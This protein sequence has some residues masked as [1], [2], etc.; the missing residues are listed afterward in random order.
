[1]VLVVCLYCGRARP[2]V[3][4]P[5][6]NVGRDERGAERGSSLSAEI[7]VPFCPISALALRVSQNVQKYSATCAEMQNVDVDVAEGKEGMSMGCCRVEPATMF[8]QSQGRSLLGLL[9]AG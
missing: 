5:Y 3:T 7:N 4:K 8:L 9:L 1:M 2:T 6:R